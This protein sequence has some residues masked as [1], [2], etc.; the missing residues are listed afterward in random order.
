M[1][2]FLYNHNLKSYIIYFPS[3]SLTTLFP[4]TNFA[5][6]FRSSAR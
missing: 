2:L 6:T 4:F 5:A 1:L 3:L